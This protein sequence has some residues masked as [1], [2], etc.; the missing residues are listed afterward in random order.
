VLEKE[1]KKADFLA[2][3]IPKAGLINVD[4]GVVHNVT[5]SLCRTANEYKSNGNS[6]LF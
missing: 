6:N 5:L 1:I 3:L 4:C 2:I